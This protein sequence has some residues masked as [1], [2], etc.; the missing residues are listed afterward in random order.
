[1]L[2]MMIPNRYAWCNPYV[3]SQAERYRKHFDDLYEKGLA[4]EK[5]FLQKLASKPEQPDIMMFWSF[6][7]N[8]A[9]MMS[10]CRER[11]INMG[12]WEDGFFP[13]YKTLH[14]DP[15]GFCWESSLTRMV[16]RGVSERQRARATRARED[17]LKKPAQ[18]LPAGVKQPYVLWPLQLIGDQVNRWDLDVSDWTGLLKHFRANLPPGVQLVVKDHPAAREKDIGG[19]DAL[20]PQ[21]R[22]TLRVPKQA[23]LAALLRECRAVAG[24]NSSVLSEARLMFKKP[25]YAYGRSWFTNHGELFFPLRV[26][27]SESLPRLD[28]LEEPSR[29]RTD[30]LDDYADWFLAQLLGRQLES[31]VA[32]S[33]PMKLKKKMWRLSYRSYVEYG[34]EIF[35][36]E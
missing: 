5:E 24:A 1:M 12:F 30:Y 31:K 19:L 36:D 4:T 6:C 9:G 21:L 20:I 23:D 35:E 17:W 25:A 2:R 29:M 11:G 3:N 14:F 32:E 18:P 7:R 13:H 8:R 22:N 33:D 28:W 10:Q 15:L 34:E 27:A 16:F 26:D